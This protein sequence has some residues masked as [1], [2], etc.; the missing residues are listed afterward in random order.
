MIQASSDSFSLVLASARD[1]W[2]EL[3]LYYPAIEDRFPV[4][5]ELIRSPDDVKQVIANYLEEERFEDV[6]PS[7][8]AYFPF[9]ESALDPPNRNERNYLKAYSI[10][11]SETN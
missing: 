2:N 11:M 1:A 10:R 5:V 7:G 6:E 4:T 8:N 9:S 3:K